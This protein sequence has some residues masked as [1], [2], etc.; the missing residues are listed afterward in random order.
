MYMYLET[1]FGVCSLKIHCGNLV[2]GLKEC[3]LWFVALEFIMRTLQ[4]FKEM[5]FLVC[6]SKKH[7]GNST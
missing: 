3:N 7:Y 1:Q 2:H 6:S 5:W 4:M